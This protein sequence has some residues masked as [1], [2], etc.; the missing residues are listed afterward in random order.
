MSELNI[1]LEHQHPIPA[2]GNVSMNQTTTSSNNNRFSINEADNEAVPTRHP[3]TFA[4]AS[5]SAKLRPAISSGS[6]HKLAVAPQNFVQDDMVLLNNARSSVFSHTMSA[7]RSVNDLDQLPGISGHHLA[8]NTLPAY[9]AAPDYET[10]IRN[11]LGGIQTQQQQISWSQPKFITDMV[12]SA[13]PPPQAGG[14]APQPQQGYS[15]HEADHFLQQQQAVVQ[16]AQGGGSHQGQGGGGGQQNL[17]QHQHPA[18]SIYS[19]STPEL[20]RINLTYHMKPNAPHAPHP[21]ANNSAAQA[22]YQMPTQD[23]I[24]AELQRLNLYKPPP[25]YP[26]TNANGQ[27][28]HVIG[29][30]AVGGMLNGGGGGHHGNHADPS[31]TRMVSST[32]TPDLASTNIMNNHVS[33]S[34]SGNVF[35]GGSSPDLVSRK[36]LGRVHNNKDNTTLH[37]TMENLHNFIEPP[38]PVPPPPP[39]APPQMHFEEETQ[40]EQV[41]GFSKQVPIYFSI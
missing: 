10:A 15:I 5:A 19:T 39:P 8:Q 29:G 41:G 22:V 24:F 34:H 32:S 6:V 36:N 35:L 38:P 25:P 11:K 27:H 7:A 40:M 37:K 4:P 3:V 28:Q 21:A 2:G 33:V 18:S 23:Q 1:T 12:P 14:V 26:G 16:A 9:R 30:H 20:N 13:G 17:T 31:Q